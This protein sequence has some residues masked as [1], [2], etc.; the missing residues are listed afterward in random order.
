MEKQ[1][2]Q[3]WTLREWRNPRKNDVVIDSLGQLG[4]VISTKSIPNSIERNLWVENVDGEIVWENVSPKEFQLASHDQT[5]KFYLAYK[6][7]KGWKRGKV[8]CVAN[9]DHPLLLVDM[10]YDLVN[11][12]MV[13]V[14]KDLTSSEEKFL[15]TMKEELIEK[16]EGDSQEA[17]EAAFLED[18]SSSLRYA[19]DVNIIDRGESFHKVGWSVSGGALKFGEIELAMAEIQ[20]WVSRMK[21]RRVA[22]VL[23]KTSNSSYAEVSITESG[24]L[25]VRDFS[26]DS[27][28]PA[29]FNSKISA[30][31]AIATIPIETWRNALSNDIDTYMI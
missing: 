11:Q 9:R 4:F 20:R 28:Q 21:I 24:N 19:I 8:Y 10:E 22:S 15:K 26:G 23:S 13:Y 5:R 1:I 2:K 31:I 18:E 27:G 3:D 16:I 7:R 17:A 30:G 29:V 12:E 25:F 6:E 14:F